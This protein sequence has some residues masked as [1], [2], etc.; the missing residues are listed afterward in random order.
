MCSS[1]PESVNLLLF[2]IGSASKLAIVKNIPSDFISLGLNHYKVEKICFE[3]QK[4]INSSY[5]NE[6][7][8]FDRPWRFMPDI[9]K[10]STLSYWVKKLLTVRFANVLHLDYK[11][12][13]L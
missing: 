1:V 2:Y 12:L 11:D 8:L 13:N 3:V 9:A 6:I 7:I 10:C 4:K 5:I